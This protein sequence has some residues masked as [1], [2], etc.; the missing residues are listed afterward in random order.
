MNG[1]Q[2]RVLPAKPGDSVCCITECED[3]GEGDNR[4]GRPDEYPEVYGVG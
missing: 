4:T 2:V 3:I 1:G